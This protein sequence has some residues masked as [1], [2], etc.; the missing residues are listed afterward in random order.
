VA[1]RPPYAA[2]RRRKA[3]RREVR[4][5]HPASGRFVRRRSS[6]RGDPEAEAGCGHAGQGGAHAPIGEARRRGPACRR[7]CAR[8]PQ[9]ADFAEGVSAA[10][11]IGFVFGSQ[12]R[13]LSH[14]HAGGIGTDRANSRRTARA[15]PPQLRA[16]RQDPHRAID[17]PCRAAAATP[18]RHARRRDRGA[19]DFGDGLHLLRREFRSNR[20][21]STS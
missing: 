16:I 8:D 9:S 6:G 20:C 10:A 17:P 11:Q 19:P 3:R 12:A 18:G 13:R 2:G 1:A 21:S 4:G 15:L 7:H 14:H 5:R